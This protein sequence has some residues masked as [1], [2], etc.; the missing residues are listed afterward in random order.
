MDIFIW[1]LP[2]GV[3][4]KIKAICSHCKP[5]SILSRGYYTP[6]VLHAWSTTSLKYNQPEV[7]VE[8]VTQ[9]RLATWTTSG[10]RHRRT[11]LCARESS[12]NQRKKN[13]ASF[14]FQRMRRVRAPPPITHRCKEK[15]P[16]VWSTNGSH[17]CLKCNIC[18]VWKG[19]FSQWSYC[20]EEEVL[21][22]QKM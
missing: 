13:E 1:N 7:P 14:E 4:D 8:G 22:Y 17:S 18:T 6:E 12:T 10:A 11:T 16:V 9:H 3:V 2:D 19:F 5:G 15:T 21:Y 20:W